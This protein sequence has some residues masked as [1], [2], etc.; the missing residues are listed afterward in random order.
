MDHS[1]PDNCETAQAEVMVQR[2]DE[3][4]VLPPAHVAKTS[5]VNMKQPAV[6]SYMTPGLH[7]MKSPVKAAARPLSY[8]RKRSLSLPGSQERV[9]MGRSELQTPLGPSLLDG[10][11]K[12]LLTDGMSTCALQ[13]PTSNSEVSPRNSLCASQS[14]CL[15]GLLENGPPTNTPLTPPVKVP[16]KR[17][18][19]SK[20][21]LLLIKMAQELE[22]QSRGETVETVPE[23]KET[24]LTQ[25]GRPR[26]RAAKT[27]MKYL[28]DIA[29]EWAVSGLS[30][31]TTPDQI[32]PED[33]GKKRRR[34]R[35]AEDSDDDVDFVVSHEALLTE[36]REEREEIE[37][38][39]LSEESDS[40]LCSYRMSVFAHREKPS[41]QMR[42]C[43]ENGFHNSIMAPVW[44]SAQITLDYRNVWYSDWEFAEWIPC[45]DNWHFLSPREA[46]GYLPLQTTSPP[47]SI[48]REGI[49]EEADPCVLSRFQS[50]PPHRERWDVTFFVGG[51]VWSLEWC[52]TLGG[53]GSCQYVALY[54]HRGMDD[55]HRLDVTHTG[56]GLLQLWSLG[57]IGSDKGG[58][59]GPSFSYGLAMDEGCIWD[60]KFCPSGGW[61][62]PCTS[63]KSTEMPRLGLLAVAFSS[64]HVEIY[65]LPHPGPLYSHRKS[66]VKDSSELTICKVDCVVRLH[67]GSIKACNPG[68]NGQCFT[69]A[70]LPSK[71]HQYL[72]AGF[73][74]GT[75]SIWDLKTK[76][77]LQKVRQGRVIKQYPF[78]SF[79]A[80]DHAVRSIEWCKADRHGLCGIHYVDSGFL[81]Y[82][83]YFVT[84]RK[85]TVWS[86]SGSDWLNTI[87]AGDI[88]GEVMVIVLPGLNVQSVNTKRPS[89]R[90]F[91]VYKADFLSYA[92]QSDDA[93]H[94]DMTLPSGPLAE[95]QDWE[96]FK[97]KSFRAAVGRFSLLFQDM[98]LRTFHRLHNREPVKRMQANEMK[99]DIN[100]ERV[101]LEAIH[102]V[103]FSPNLDTYPWI[104]SG[105]H[106][107]LVRVH[108]VQGLVS[109]VG[110]KMIQEK[111]AQFRAMFEDIETITECD[112]SPEVQHCVV[113]V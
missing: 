68:E 82:K 51:P 19:K 109:S 108:C 21:E 102:K 46:E 57:S 52:P 23:E 17:G 28:Q 41:P 80:H 48:R 39:Y 100:M 3:D 99:S 31:S 12:T 113:Q 81:G 63:R 29:D 54:C 5:T 4:S 26:R 67:V 65:S 45:I 106:S 36:E 40:D 59:S 56:P 30:S 6:V 58:D 74:D 70:W 62:L 71:P 73:Y 35:K 75:V 7:V 42:G 34:K 72:A 1:V 90:R 60:L 88:N 84:P 15:A 24:E 37:I 95:S 64:G 86:I 16:K 38:D 94:S 44:S 27:A 111:S 11:N 66:Q 8:K 97:P 83:P 96:H 2:R 110:R 85:G 43:A 91:P 9:T 47:F 32:M 103:R 22:A 76:S 14:P 87:S 10:S 13:T 104:V 98:D 112:Y 18:R 107:G 105:G 49:Q 25:S 61:E 77:V 92:P 101:Q 20:A 53:S 50:L 69:V 93:H 55:R 79:S 89:E 78:H 33:T